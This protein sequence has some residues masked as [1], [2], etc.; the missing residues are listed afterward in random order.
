MENVSSA[1]TQNLTLETDLGQ[2]QE[3]AKEATIWAFPMVENYQSIYNL[4]IA[5]NSPNF[6]GKMNQINNVERVYTPADTAIITPNSEKINEDKSHIPQVLILI[7]DF[8]VR[9]GCNSFSTS[10]PLICRNMSFY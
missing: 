2:V 10:I 6:K 9:N 3:I 7:G 5:S 1:N 8:L 4:A